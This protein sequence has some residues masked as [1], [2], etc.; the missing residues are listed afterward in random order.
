MVCIL[1]AT[2]LVQPGSACAEVARDRRPFMGE[3][4]STLE[5]HYYAYS[6]STDRI[7]I[8]ERSDIGSN[9]IWKQTV[10]ARIS[11]SRFLRPEI[12][13]VSADDGAAFYFEASSRGNFFA[14]NGDRGD[15][16]TDW[17]YVPLQRIDVATCENA[18]G[19]I[20]Q[21]RDYVADR[22]ASFPELEMI[23]RQLQKLERE[24]GLSGYGRK[25]AND[26]ALQTAKLLRD[27]A[28]PM[29][30][31][32]VW[33]WAEIMEQGREWAVAM[34]NAG[35]AIGD[36]VDLQK[37]AEALLPGIDKV[38]RQFA[39]IRQFYDDQ[40]RALAERQCVRMTGKG[41]YFVLTRS[42]LVDATQDLAFGMAHRARS[43]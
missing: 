43:E 28:S 37:R 30:K 12:L 8:Y 4:V 17:Y 34:V 9:P 1:A 14:T 24:A 38:N 20:R 5:G 39:A 7:V 35:L 6:L 19:Q 11:G 3:W 31:L 22:N 2:M 41:G 33:E 25:E 16:V 42:G 26:L 29:N 15:G 21:A 32:K 23:A 27:V 10:S 18:L 40:M 36:L 13:Q